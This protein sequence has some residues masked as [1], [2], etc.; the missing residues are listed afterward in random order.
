M[1]MSRAIYVGPYFQTEDK[2]SDFNH[3]IY[4]YA[5]MESM[6]FQEIGDKLHWMPNID[7]KPPRKFLI[8]SSEINEELGGDRN[9][10]E[11]DWLFENFRVDHDILL[12]NYDSVVVKWGIFSFIW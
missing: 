9:E 12:E 8:D 1:G 6:W 2:G 10:F 11:K 7:K 4:E 5:V 3:D